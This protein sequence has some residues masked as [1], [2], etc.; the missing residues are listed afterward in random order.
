MG[1]IKRPLAQVRRVADD[2]LGILTPACERIEIAG[3]LRRCKDTIGDIELVAIPKQ[4]LDLF[5]EPIPETQ[6]DQLLGD[7]GVRFTRNGPKF[8]QFDAYN[9]QLNAHN[10]G[11]LYQVDLFVVPDPATWGVIFMIRTG[12]A[13]FSRKMVTRKCYGGLM[14]SDLQVAKGRVT[15]PHRNRKTEILETPEEEDIF[16]LWGMSFVNPPDR[17][18]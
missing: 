12:S 11:D 7:L 15:L 14:P 17:E 3:S 6:L 1:K 16:D 8:K 10:G 9:K 4:N 18:I 2:L 13:A 5:G